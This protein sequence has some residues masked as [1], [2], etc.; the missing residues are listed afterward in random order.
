MAPIRILIADDH[1]IIRQGLASHPRDGEPD[2]ELVGEAADGA[3]AHQACAPNY[4]RTWC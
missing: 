3:E 2:F 4:T 1:L